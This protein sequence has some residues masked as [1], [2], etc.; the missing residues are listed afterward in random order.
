MSIVPF[1][2]ALLGNFV[3]LA[4]LSAQAETL[5]EMTIASV[6]LTKS[7]CFQFYH[8]K[9]MQVIKNLNLFSITY[10]F[11]CLVFQSAVRRSKNQFGN[12][13]LVAMISVLLALLTVTWI[14]ACLS[15]LHAALGCQHH[16]T[17]LQS[18]FSTTLQD[19]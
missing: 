1:H 19:D 16:C 11:F 3:L 15:A 14:E 6:F 4:E 8:Y 10:N 18:V 12:E 7:A 2:M 9:K 5:T 17:Y 13:L